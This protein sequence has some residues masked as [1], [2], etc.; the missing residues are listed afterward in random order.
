MKQPTTHSQ[1]GSSYYDT[2]TRYGHGGVVQHW[3]CGHMAGGG[4][5]WIKKSNAKSHT[6]HCVV[7]CD[8]SICSSFLSD[9]VRTPMREKSVAPNK[10]QLD[11]VGPAL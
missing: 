2:V 5:S 1:I 8:F 7:L 3:T 11:Y 6:Q 9:D 4:G 10:T